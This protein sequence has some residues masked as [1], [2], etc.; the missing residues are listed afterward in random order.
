VSNPEPTSYF[1][2][3]LA[4]ATIFYSLRF[5]TSLLSPPTTPRTTVEVFDPASIRDSSRIESSRVDSSHMLRPTVSRP[6]CFG[7]NTHLGLTTRCLLLS[8]SFGFVDMGVC[9]LQLL[10]AL[11]STVI[12]GSKSRGTRDHILLSQIQKRAQQQKSFH[13]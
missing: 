6:V 8:D 12:L 1:S 7:K 11:V 13:Y 10:L 2:G 3:Y 5:E 9:L 4:N